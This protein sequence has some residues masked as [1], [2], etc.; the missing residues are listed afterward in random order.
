MTHHRR[1]TY[2]LV[3]VTH[4]GRGLFRGR[5]MSGV[6]GLLEIRRPIRLPEKFAFLEN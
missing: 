3:K 1:M 6:A 2:K 5:R 4:L